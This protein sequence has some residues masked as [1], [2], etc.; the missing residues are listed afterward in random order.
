MSSGRSSGR[1]DFSRFNEKLEKHVE[2]LP[3]YAQRAQQK[4]QRYLPPSETH[5][6]DP[7]SPEPSRP[8]SQSPQRLV[9]PSLPSSAA[10]IPVVAEVRASWARWNDPAV[11]L[12]RQT[13]RT[14]RALTLWV[15]LTFL[16]ALIVVAGVAGAFGAGI[17]AASM[18]VLGGGAGV[19]VFGTLGVRSGVRL[20][21]LKRTELPAK[22][23]PSPL[24]SPASA[25][26]Q[27]MERLRE[28]E[29]SLDELLT[30][31]SAPVGGAPSAV[32]ELSVEQARLTAREAAAA[33]RGLA[34]RVQAIER[35]RD[36]APPAEQG[37]L[38]SAVKTLR[39]QL[40]DGLI[41]Y[42]ELVAAAGRAVAASSG[43]TGSARESLTDAT[44]HLA[45][46]AIALRE[47]S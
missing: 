13:R 18:P 47:L 40:D 46:L 34:A 2:R 23:T 10:D 26:R 3:D 42:G 22:A 29:A 14:S 9:I 36:H 15:I 17:A 24:P 33:L 45:G 1:R 39:E 41:G 30:Q 20:R 27:P 6:R 43:G 31:L 37:A 44:D 32:P 7:A 28:S 19:V 35:G 8:Q 25:A 5:G 38:D 16:C 12:Q 4:L 21:T 11:K